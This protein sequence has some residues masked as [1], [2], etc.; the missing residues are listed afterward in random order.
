[1]AGGATLGDGGRGAVTETAK[2]IV[3][4]V[5]LDAGCGLVGVVID[6]ILHL[7]KEVVDLNKILLCACIR[8]HGEVVLLCKR[9]GS[10]AVT[11]GYGLGSVTLGGSHGSLWD[12]HGAM[13]RKQRAA[14]SVVGSRVDL[15]TLGTAE[16]VVDHVK[17]TLLMGSV[18][19]VVAK[20]LG[21]LVVQRRL[22][23]VQAVVS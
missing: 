21:A 2:L 16:K 10:R 15:L 5:N 13:E 12:G 7:P 19:L 14:D 4:A 23:E 17:G 3:T 22:V 8:G 6:G 20:V 18:G 11:H 1:M 9:V